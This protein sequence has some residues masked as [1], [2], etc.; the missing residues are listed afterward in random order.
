VTAEQ[1]AAQL[2]DLAE[3]E[4][5]AL[6]RAAGRF[7]ARVDRSAGPHGCWEWRGG[8]GK[9]GYGQFYLGKRPMPAH[10]VAWQLLRGPIPAGLV[11]DHLCRN[12]LCVNVRHLAL[13][14]AGE[15]VLRGQSPAAINARKTHCAASGHPLAGPN[16][17]VHRGD[18]H[19]R[20]C[21]RMHDRLYR[22]R[23]LTSRR[24]T[25][26]TPA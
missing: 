18:R 24:P 1:L 9:G 20:A 11:C 5:R 23:R 16:L 12:R 14:T 3:P 7:W 21:K 8:L 26:R 13:V 22:Q 10:R 15:N 25:E 2:A 17:Y 4:L 6:A 19:C